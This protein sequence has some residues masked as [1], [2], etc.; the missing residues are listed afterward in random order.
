MSSGYIVFLRQNLT[1]FFLSG[2]SIVFFL[3]ILSGPG[4]S[5]GGQGWRD[6]GAFWRWR[7]VAI[8]GGGG[9]GSGGSGRM[10]GEN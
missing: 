2:K 6:S 7:R 9:K 1:K 4:C 5:T 8:S 10:V 3:Y